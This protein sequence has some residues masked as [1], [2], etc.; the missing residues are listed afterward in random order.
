MSDNVNAKI[1]S[2][3]ASLA[4][5]VREIIEEQWGKRLVDVKDLSVGQFHERL[6]QRGSVSYRPA[7]RF[8]LQ[9]QFFTA[10]EPRWST[11]SLTL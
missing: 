11:F 4:E 6:V 9:A 8:I 7:N 3:N 5:K 1:S 2:F 10:R